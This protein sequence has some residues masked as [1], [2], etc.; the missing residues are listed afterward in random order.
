MRKNL[1]HSSLEFLKRV[2]QTAR[3]MIGIPDYENYVK[4][5]KL[6]HPN[7]PVMSYEEFFIER[8]LN[9]YDGKKPGRCC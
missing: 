3:Q 5:R 4:H 6:K 8:Q 7:S 1:L 9:R 2:Q